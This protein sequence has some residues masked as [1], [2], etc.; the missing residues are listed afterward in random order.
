MRLALQTDYA[1]RT[2]MYLA[3][4]GERAT[5]A[6]VANFYG[7]SGPHVAKVVNQLARWGFVRSVRGAGGGI[8]LARPPDA[9]RIGEV[10]AAFEG[11][12]H[13]LECVETENVCVVQKY[14]KLKNVLAEAERL[15]LEYLNRATIA[16]VLPSRQQMAAGAGP[17]RS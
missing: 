9:I 7:I 15:Q 4:H 14:C 11:N 10:I 8:Q 17:R 2:L 13:L 3:F 16:D 12:L 1:L 5:A 6:E